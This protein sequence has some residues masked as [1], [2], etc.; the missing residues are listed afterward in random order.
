MDR[1]FLRWEGSEG[2]GNDLAATAAASIDA[3]IVWRVGGPILFVELRAGADLDVIAAPE[4][5][6]EAPSFDSHI[7]VATPIDKGAH[8]LRRSDLRHIG[9]PPYFPSQIPHFRDWALPW[10]AA[11]FRKIFMHAA[12][13][14]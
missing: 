14:T 2:L 9:E 6:H 13:A 5:R 1:V 7:L 3:G 10:L 11:R 12:Q 8:T 4:Q